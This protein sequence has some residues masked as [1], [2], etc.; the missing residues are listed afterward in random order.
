MIEELPHSFTSISIF[1]NRAI[2]MLFN[3]LTLFTSLL[4]LTS[5]VALRKGAINKRAAETSAL[6]AYGQNI[7]G[8]EIFYGD[9]L[10]YI[11]YTRPTWLTSTSNIT[12][13]YSLLFLPSY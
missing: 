3:T 11:G 4:G 8:L 5:A 13:M 9:G 10:A 6:Y 1:E 2:T 7:S 12:C